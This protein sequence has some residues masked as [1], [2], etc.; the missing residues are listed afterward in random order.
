M[1]N[2]VSDVTMS[3]YDVVVSV[4]NGVINVCVVVPDVAD[5]I[6]GGSATIK[7]DHYSK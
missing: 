3:P 7:G 5:V 1:L 6:I 4:F 2:V